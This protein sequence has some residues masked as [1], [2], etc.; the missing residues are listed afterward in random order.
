[1]SQGGFP[2]EKKV[3][4][5]ID[6]NVG[7]RWKEIDKIQTR[8]K[9]AQNPQSLDFWLDFLM[10]SLGIRKAKEGVN[11]VESIHLLYI[12]QAEGGQEKSSPIWARALP[13]SL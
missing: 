3:M 5:R 11:E 8:S 9:V 2:T 12:Y 4:S 1:M 10:G 13:E 6:A 7:E